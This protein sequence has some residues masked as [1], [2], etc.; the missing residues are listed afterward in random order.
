ML[1]TNGRIL[2]VMSL[3]LT[4]ALHAQATD[5]SI[6]DQ[7]KHLRGFSADQRPAAT[8]KIALDI[9]TLPDGPR[10]LQLADGL[11]HLA[12]E[13]DA[14]HATLQAVADTLTEA[15]ATSPAVAKA[16]STAPAMPY[17]DLANLVRYEGVIT[18]LKDPQFT[19]AKA[20]LVAEEA[21]IDGVD[22]TLKDLHGKSW[23]L[24]QLR[25]KIV[26]VN[27]WATWGPPCRL[28]MPDLDAIYTKYESQ[29]LVIVSLSSEDEAKISALIEK[30]QYHPPVLLDTGGDVANQFHVNGIPR[31]FIFDRN[32]KLA[33]ESIDMRTQRQFLE[34]LA[35]AG[36]HT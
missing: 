3:F 35:K 11:S 36:L 29:G 8:M 2:L 27:F 10:K 23:T 30:T 25:G 4:P 16:G 6:V 20:M 9:R 14:G 26:L 31:S 7:L 33:A 1:T 15:L 24:S 12:T 32:G 17:L 19:K 34:L 21:S 18:T 5:A 28:E 13:G 22:F